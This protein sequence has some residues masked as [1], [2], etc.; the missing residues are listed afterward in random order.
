MLILTRRPGEWVEIEPRQ[1]APAGMTVAEL[2]AGGPIRVFLG[3]IN[4]DRARIGILAPA[5]LRILRSELA[6][7]AAKKRD[8][9][10]PCR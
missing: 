7:K 9:K 10:S 3:P 5:E 2:F 6:I 8:S 4:G 1:E